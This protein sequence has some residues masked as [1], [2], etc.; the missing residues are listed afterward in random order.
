MPSL[1]LE[2]A[3][4]LGGHEGD[5]LACAYTPDSSCLLSAGWDGKLQLWDAAQG[6]FVDQ[7]PVS[8]KPLSACTVS[9]DGKFWLVGTMDG[10][11][12]RWD[13]HVRHQLSIFLA[14]TRPIS[15]LVFS[16]DGQQLA[17]SS[18]DR[19]V[20]LWNL[21][22]SFEGKPLGAV[23]LFENL[24]EARLVNTTFKQSGRERESVGSGIPIPEPPTVGGQANKKR[25]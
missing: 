3:A 16:P 2:D 1:R 23:I 25:E 22:R 18:W 15:A 13:A 20:S 19:N 8:D 11:L 21:D 9:P 4:C 10:L 17:S 7:I 6:A 5:V 14:H 12:A 24:V